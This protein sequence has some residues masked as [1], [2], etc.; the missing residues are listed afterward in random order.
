[1]G[2][3]AAWLVNCHCFLISGNSGGLEKGSICKAT[4]YHLL[5]GLPYCGQ[6]LGLCCLA[7]DTELI[8][9]TQFLLAEQ[10]HVNAHSDALQ[11]VHSA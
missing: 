10:L 1:M 3:H 2:V 4:R 9:L 8:M 11:L 6:G 7:G 5:C